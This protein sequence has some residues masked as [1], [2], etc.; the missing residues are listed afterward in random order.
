MNL[1]LSKL[2]V[3]DDCSDLHSGSCRPHSSPVTFPASFLAFIYIHLSTLSTFLNFIIFFSSFFSFK[4]I[5]LTHAL[6]LFSLPHSLHSC[7][8]PS[9][10]L[11]FLYSFLYSSLNY[12][13]HSSP[14]SSRL[15]HLSL[16]LFSHFLLLHFLVLVS[17]HYVHCLPRFFL[18]SPFFRSF[19]LLTP[20]VLRCIFIFSFGYNY[21]TLLTSGKL[22]ICTSEEEWADSSLI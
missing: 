20:S 18:F 16:Q 17:F 12:S 11:F 5:T 4:T 22:A 6:T 7:L 15:M 21:M 13:Y 10:L 1:P 8:L 2:Q 14:F 9:A 19:S 3:P